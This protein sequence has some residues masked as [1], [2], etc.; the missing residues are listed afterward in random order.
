MADAHEAI[1]QHVL[2]EA[3]D[4]LFAAE[5]HHF[6]PV[7]ITV[8]FVTEAYLLLIVV[9][10]AVVVDSNLV[11]IA[12]KIGDDGFSFLDIGLG[13]DHPFILHELIEGGTDLFIIGEPMQRA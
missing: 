4:E 3:A 10:E 7:M 11:G 1:R 13:V 2:Q 8:V 12:G 9:D 5:S 6:L